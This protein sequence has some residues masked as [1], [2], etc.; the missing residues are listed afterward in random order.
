M[1]LF[2][3]LVAILVIIAIIIAVVAVAIYGISQ[4]INGG[5]NWLL[6]KICPVSNR[7]DFYLTKINKQNKHKTNWINKPITAPILGSDAE[8]FLKDKNCIFLWNRKNH[9][10]QQK[11]VLIQIKLKRSGKIP[12]K[13]PATREKLESKKRK[14]E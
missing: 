4:Y 13:T 7:T 8:P 11:P 10:G 12:P 6:Q 5:G 2:T 3:I 14:I 1:D 9:L